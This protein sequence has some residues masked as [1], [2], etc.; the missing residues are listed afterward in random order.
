MLRLSLLLVVLFTLAACR[1]LPPPVPTPPDEWPEVLEGLR[2]GRDGLEEASQALGVEGTATACPADRRSA[3]PS[4]SCICFERGDAR[5]VLISTV[6]VGSPRVVTGAMLLRGGETGC[7]SSEGSQPLA[8]EGVTLDATRLTLRRW[9][10]HLPNHG[11]LSATRSRSMR[12][13]RRL[14]SGQALLDTV[15]LVKRVDVDASGR[16]HAISAYL[17]EVY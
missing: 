8:I 16:L 14:S 6:P 10:F 9:D 5:L 13:P 2:L 4:P 1:T 12:V 3:G 17:V 15:M 11:P 7:A